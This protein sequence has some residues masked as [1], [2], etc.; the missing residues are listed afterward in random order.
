MPKLA[1]LDMSGKQV[2]EIVLS[3]A[4]FGI[5]P[6]QAVLHDAVVMQQASL[7]RGTHATKIVQLFVGAARNRGDKKE[8]VVHVTA[9]FVPRCG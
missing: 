4:V 9:A 7:R 8:P 1:V 5:T 3:D 2:D 6:N